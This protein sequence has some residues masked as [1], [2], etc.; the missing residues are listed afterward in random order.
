MF[1]RE[2][3]TNKD[4]VTAAIDEL[5]AEMHEQ[6][7]DSEIYND[8]VAQLTKLYELKEIDHKVDSPGRISMDTLAIVAANVVG[9]AMIVM[10]ER[11]NVITSKALPLL[12]K[13]R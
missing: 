11:E 1:N 3:N 4:G 10:H 5:L 12:A 2:P 8:M 13:L 9:I 7:K 6:D